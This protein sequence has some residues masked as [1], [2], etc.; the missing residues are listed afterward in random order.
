VTAPITFESVDAVGGDEKPAKKKNTQGVRQ[1]RDDANLVSMSPESPKVEPTMVALSA[2]KREKALICRARGLNAATV[3]EYAAA[4]TAGAE[5]PPVVV[6]RDGKGVHWLGDGHH[7][8]EAAKAAGRTE[9]LADVREGGRKEALLHAARANGEHGLRRTTAD[10]QRAVEL[11]LA[12]CPK[13]TDRQ[14]GEA[15]GVDHKTVAAA[16]RRK[17]GGEIPQKPTAVEVARRRLDRVAKAWPKGES[18]IP[19]VE[20]AKEWLATLDPSSSPQD[21]RKIEFTPPEGA[22]HG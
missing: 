16:K 7:R 2:I 8:T 5:F 18:M 15:C 17:S 9:I 14:V 10:K 6:F 4:M 22:A 21:A 20:A 3:K 12:A 13:M 11:V 19:L 1:R